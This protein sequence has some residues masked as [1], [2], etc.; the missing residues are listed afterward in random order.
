MDKQTDP[1]VEK[2]ERK[3]RIRTQKD[4]PEIAGGSREA[5]RIAALVL[6]V[7]AGAIKPAEAAAALGMNLPRYYH[8]EKRALQ[9]LLEAC[10]PGSPG[11]RENA[12]KRDV[13]ALEKKVRELERDVCRYQTLARA[14]QR[15]LGI[16]ERRAEKAGKGK[17]RRPT[18]RALKIVRQLKREE[19]PASEGNV[20]V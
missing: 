4:G 10:E 9:G 18:V 5:R 20:S 2:K 15:T 12:E 6:E 19:P 16:P 8:V 17:R 3:K 11:R 7:L 14:A 1:I 13:A